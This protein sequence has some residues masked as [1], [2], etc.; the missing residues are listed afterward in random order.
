MH[1]IVT[2]GPTYEPL[3]EVRRLT[4]FSSGK[5]GTTLANFL[6][7]SGHQ[8][9]LLRGHYSTFHGEASAQEIQVFTTTRDLQDRFHALGSQKV[10][11]IFHAAAVSDFGFG[12]IFEQTDG[13]LT[14]VKSGKV[15]TRG[16]RLM[17]ELVPTPKILPQLRGWFPDAVIIGWKYEVDGKRDD[18][19][20]KARKQIIEANST[21]CVANGP[22]FGAGFGLVTKSETTPFLDENELFVALA[23]IISST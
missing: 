7:E 10:G 8:V 11:A 1:C 17:A 2:A 18:A 3:D 14:E 5:L 4:N 15:S 20:A 9:T 16:G 12:K 13:I 23:G 21:A 19:I 6:V 22:A